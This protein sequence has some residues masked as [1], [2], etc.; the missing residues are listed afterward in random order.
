M[1]NNFNDKLLGTLFCSLLEVVTVVSTRWHI[2]T[3]LHGVTPQNT[4][5][6]TEL[7]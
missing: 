7:F 3:E 2:F 5:I 4:L 1:A 6:W